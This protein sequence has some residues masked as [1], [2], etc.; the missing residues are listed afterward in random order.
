MVSH[1]KCWQGTLRIR[2]FS[3]LKMAVVKSFFFHMPNLRELWL[4]NSLLDSKDE[5]ETARELTDDFNTRHFRIQL[6]FEKWSSINCLQSIHMADLVWQKFMCGIIWIL[7]WIDSNG[8]DFYDQN[9][10]SSQIFWTKTRL[11]RK[12][13]TPYWQ[14]IFHFRRK[15]IDDAHGPPMFPWECGITRKWIFKLLDWTQ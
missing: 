12:W 8:E 7:I 15:I 3:C 11:S 4:P 13:K 1:L 14:T 2:K 6:Q 10:E 9:L 5:N